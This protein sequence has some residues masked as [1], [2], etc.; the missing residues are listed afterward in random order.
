MDYEPPLERIA[1]RI[2]RSLP[3]PTSA[4]LDQ[5]ERSLVVIGEDLV[6]ARNEFGHV[7][8]H[9]TDQAVAVETDPITLERVYLGPFRIL[10]RLDRL[11]NCTVD[12]T[13]EVVAVNPHPATGNGRVTHPHVSDGRLCAGEATG[14]LAAALQDG[15]ICDTFLLVRSVLE[16]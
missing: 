14:P 6:Q 4:G 15:R 5:V 9:A 7:S 12:A 8:F 11:A 1:V 10:I 13:I 3:D 16:T 2:R